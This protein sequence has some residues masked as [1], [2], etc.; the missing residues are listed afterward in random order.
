M[1]MDKRSYYWIKLHTA[2]LSNSKFLMLSTSAKYHYIV[3]YLLSCEGDSGGV[4]VQNEEVL[5]VNEMAFLLHE[6]E[7]NLKKSI[8]ELVKV[9]LILDDGNGVYT[10][11]RFLEDQ[12]KVS[13][14]A[15]EDKKKQQWRIRQARHR[16]KVHS[17]TYRDEERRI[18]SN[19]Y[20]EEE[21]D[22]KEK[23][24]KHPEIDGEID[25]EVDGEIDGEIDGDIDRDIE[26]HTIVTGDTCVTRSDI[27]E[28]S[29]HFINI[30]D[31]NSEY[32]T[33][34]YNLIVG[35][36]WG[37]FYSVMDV[38]TR[39]GVYEEFSRSIYSYFPNQEQA[40]SMPYLETTINYCLWWMKSQD[41][42]FEDFIKEK[43]WEC[44][45]INSET[46]DLSDFISHVNN[47][48]ENYKEPID[49]FITW[50]TNGGIEFGDISSDNMIDIYPIAF[51]PEI[52]YI[53][54]EQQGN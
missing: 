7:N 21:V 9:G 1:S 41:L 26:G 19:S 13:F 18:N 30:F 6:D 36:L 47:R 43:L 4:L 32:S 44:L 46:E 42:T 37:I 8:E 39:A 17:S 22:G 54:D 5:S 51:L 14:G 49:T 15:E 16:N 28:S 12:G 29:E 31:P 3:L 40:L 50:F 38:A 33:E 27:F 11:S 20:S 2:Y 10:I 24:E 52:S 45:Q 35:R 23:T 48:M 34:E 53:D 25:G